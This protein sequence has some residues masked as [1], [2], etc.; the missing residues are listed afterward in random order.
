MGLQLMTS[1]FLGSEN[2]QHIHTVAYRSH[3]K[4]V[5][6]SQAGAN[7]IQETGTGYFVRNPFNPY[8]DDPRARVSGAD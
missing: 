4:L 1:H 8:Y 7:T 2:R 6:H 5:A 3:G